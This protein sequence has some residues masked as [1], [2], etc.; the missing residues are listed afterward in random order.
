M[1]FKFCWTYKNETQK[2][3]KKEIKNVSLASVIGPAQIVLVIFS[4][5]SRTPI[6]RSLASIGGGDT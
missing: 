6:G 3:N 2:E 5:Q 4:Y 1:N